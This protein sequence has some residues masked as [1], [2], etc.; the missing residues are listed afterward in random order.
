MD[1]SKREEVE[2][3]QVRQS[4]RIN[5]QNN[6]MMSVGEKTNLKKEQ[7]KNEGNKNI[8]KTPLKFLLLMTA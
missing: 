1:T 4:K 7:D 2:W 3:K 8:S 5:E 6:S